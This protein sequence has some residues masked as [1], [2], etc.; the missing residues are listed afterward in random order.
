MNPPDGAA[1]DTGSRD[2]FFKIHVDSAMGGIRL[3][4]FLSRQL[5]SVSRSLVSSSIRSGLIAVD[6]V[7]RKSSYRL[8]VGEIVSGTLEALPDVDVHPQKIDFPIL[9]EDNA[10]L[11]ISK[12]PGLV[13]HPGSGHQQET[14]VNGLLYHCHTIEGVGDRLRP[15][16]VHRLDKDTSGAMV[17]AKTDVVHRSLVELFKNRRLH[18][19]YLAILHGHLA[20]KQGRIV[21]SI[22]RHPVQRQ[23]MAVRS[24]GGR[25]AASSWT[26]LRE[27]ESGYSLVNVC[28]E[29]GRTHQIRLHMAH[30]GCPVAGDAVYG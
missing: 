6:G 28:I 9:F 1:K 15:G 10:L 19:E 12:P 13:V 23:K 14:L 29:T 20:E 22:G 24:T 27:F 17:V 2:R 3:D 7:K 26:V 5:P 8:K 4:Q 18:K 16:I 25:H 21:A 11:I 30:L